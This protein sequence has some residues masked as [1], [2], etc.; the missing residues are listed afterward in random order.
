MSNE[1]ATTPK[2]FD[3]DYS[4]DNRPDNR[5]PLGSNCTKVVG[6]PALG[7]GQPSLGQ[8]RSRGLLSQLDHRVYEGCPSF[9]NFSLQGGQVGILSDF[10]VLCQLCVLTHSDSLTRSRS[11]GNHHSGVHLRLT[12]HSRGG[13]GIGRHAGFRYLC[14]RTCGFKS[15]LPHSLNS[16]TAATRYGTSPELTRYSLLNPMLTIHCLWSRFSFLGVFHRP[17]N[18]YH[19]VKVSFVN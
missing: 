6:E 3:S 17:N 18:T 11:P 12:W 9:L 1:L 2:Q 19:R 16:L 15:R 13:G 14:L 5:D 7:C 8:C 4:N 10:D